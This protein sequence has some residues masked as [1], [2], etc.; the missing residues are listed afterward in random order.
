MSHER[1][2]RLVLEAVS[3]FARALERALAELSTD[4]R[5]V[6]AAQ[7]WAAFARGLASVAWQAEASEALRRAHALFDASPSD[8]GRRSVAVCA[9]AMGD[10]VVAP[11]RVLVRGLG[12]APARGA[13][14]GG[15]PPCG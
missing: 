3:R 13:A 7:L 14:R 10:L 4:E 15:S 2:E 11:A 5:G 8:T 12:V 6:T 9:G 1:H